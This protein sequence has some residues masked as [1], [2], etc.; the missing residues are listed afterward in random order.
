MSHAPVKIKQV[1]V[2]YDLCPIWLNVISFG[3][4]S[5]QVNVRAT[6]GL[7][8]SDVDVDLDKILE[9]CQNYSDFSLDIDEHTVCKI[10]F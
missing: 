6:N 1:P 5:L 3:K 10:L 7:S 4:G 9:A 8:S 2:I